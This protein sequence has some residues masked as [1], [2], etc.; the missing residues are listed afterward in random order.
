M[1]KFIDYVMSFY[2]R[3][4]IYDMDVTREEAKAATGVRMGICKHSGVPFEGD[5]ID[6]EAVRDIIEDMRMGL[7]A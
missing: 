1:N 4:E 5:T 6:R 7:A 3:D 2:G